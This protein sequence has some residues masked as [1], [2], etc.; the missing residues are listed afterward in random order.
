VE[1]ARGFFTNLINLGSGVTH[2]LILVAILGILLRWQLEQ[3]HRLPALIATTALV[4]VFLSYCGVYLITPY[5][6][7]WQVQSS[8]DRLILQVWPSFLFV[9]FVVLRSVADAGNAPPAVKAAVTRK[10]E[11]HGR[12]EPAGKQRR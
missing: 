2:P 9:F 10:S 7:A 5:S 11:T 1:I 12:R 6:L 8:F 4:L 3:R